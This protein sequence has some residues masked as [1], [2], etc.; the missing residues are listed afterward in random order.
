MAGGGA[1]SLVE[2]VTLPLDSRATKEV[3]I[4]VYR[5]PSLGS[6]AVCYVL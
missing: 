1:A 4:V 5:Y 3:D 2:E 6:I